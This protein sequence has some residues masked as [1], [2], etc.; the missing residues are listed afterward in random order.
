MLSGTLFLVELL[1]AEFLFSFRLKKKKGYYWRLPA[2][3]FLLLA[4]SMSII[5]IGNAL[6]IS[7]NTWYTFGLYLVLFALTVVGLKFVYNEPIINVVFCGIA[8]YTTQHL[9]YQFTNV[10]FTLILWGES[11]L[12]GMY[13]SSSVDISSWSIE[14]LFWIIIYLLGYFTVYGGVWLAFG[15]R[16]K[17]G[18]DLKIKNQSFVALIGGCLVLNILLNALA[19]F[20][21]ASSDVANSIIREVSSVFNCLLL[22]QWQFELVQSKR[23][24]T[25]LDFT[26]TL[27]LQS[28]EQYKISKDNM[29]LINLKCHDMKHQIREIGSYKQ[30]D[31]E[32]IKDLEQSISVYDSVVKTE[33]EALDVILTEKS[34]K[35]LRNNVILKCIADGQSLNFM[36][37]ADVY[38]LFGNCVDNAIDAVIN[39]TDKE[40]RVISL[41]VNTVGNFV[42]INIKNFYQGV[43]PIDAEGLPTTTK[44]DKRYHGYGMKSIRMIVEKYEGNLS[45]QTKGEVFN[46]NILFPVAKEK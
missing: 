38:A 4:L 6:S 35:C 28:Q 17:K 44:A 34:F 26:K 45:I 21:N 41:K 11:P 29:D 39:L 9:A 31:P 16:I 40:K 32:T 33:N 5:L 46:V 15:R 7:N 43:I 42:T 22:L 36:K 25:E 14:S 20:S 18:E 10:L 3:V 27:L 37:S 13:H 12:L 23:L 1:V 2:T 19:V 24:Q 30:L 8:A